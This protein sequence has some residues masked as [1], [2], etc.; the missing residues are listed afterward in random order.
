M[1]ITSKAKRRSSRHAAGACGTF[2]CGG[3]RLRRHFLGRES[4][5]Q[6][7]ETRVQQDSSEEAV[8]CPSGGG[9]SPLTNTL[10]KMSHP[11]PPLGLLTLLDTQTACPRGLLFSPKGNC[12]ATPETWQIFWSRTTTRQRSS[13]PHKTR[14]HSTTHVKTAQHDATSAA[15][16]NTTQDA[17]RG[18]TKAFG[19]HKRFAIFRHPIRLAILR[20]S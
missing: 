6:T 13:T 10:L 17:T 11:L 9:S 2:V 20:N 15:Q 18:D 7:S 8:L 14:Q 4:P 19:A 12:R 3:E 1:Q 16:G 5:E